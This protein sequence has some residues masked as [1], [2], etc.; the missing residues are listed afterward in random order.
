M[1]KE[2]I[3][4]SLLAFALSV[5]AVGG[6]LW[7]G[8]LFVDRLALEMPWQKTNLSEI[9]QQVPVPVDKSN[10]NTGKQIPVTEASKGNVTLPNVVDIKMQEATFQASVKNLFQAFAKVNNAKVTETKDGGMWWDTEDGF[11]IMNSTGTQ[12]TNLLLSSTSDTNYSA[13]KKTALFLSPLI[14]RIMYENGFRLSEW[15]SSKIGEESFIGIGNMTDIVGFY[16][17]IGAYEN[18]SKKV[19]FTANPDANLFQNTPG[20]FYYTFSFSVLDNDIYVKNY[21]KQISIFKRSWF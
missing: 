19:V 10:I 21:K 9:K 6:G 5:V 16:D 18:D 7:G 17:F 3:K 2:N 20:E 8:F 14:D 11:S 12:D 4:K 13:F 15:N 1:K